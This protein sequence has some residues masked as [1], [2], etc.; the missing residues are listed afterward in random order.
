VGV[1]LFHGFPGKVEQDRE[2][3]FQY[4]QRAG[5]LGLME[6]WRNVV[7]CYATGQGVKQNLEMARYIGETMIRP[8]DEAMEYNNDATNS[9]NDHGEAF[10]DIDNQTVA[11]E[12]SPIPEDNAVKSDEK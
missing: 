12:S 6:G 8:Y 9:S 3:A 4:Y 11:V 2:R 7:D 1:A 10:D 5:E